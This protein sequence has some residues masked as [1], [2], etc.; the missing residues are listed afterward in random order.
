[1]HESRYVQ[2][3]TLKNHVQSQGV[4]IVDI[5]FVMKQSVRVRDAQSE[6]VFATIKMSI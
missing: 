6:V 4:V 1:M 5:R 3:I 2:T